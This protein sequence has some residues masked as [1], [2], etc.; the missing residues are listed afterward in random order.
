VLAARLKAAQRERYRSAVLIQGGAESR[1]TFDDTQ[2][3]V[4]ETLADMAR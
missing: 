3:S 4:E 2:S 1:K